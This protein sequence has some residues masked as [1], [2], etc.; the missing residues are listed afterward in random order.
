[1]SELRVI[2]ILVKVALMITNCTRQMLR[3]QWGEKEKV[4]EQN[5]GVLHTQG[6]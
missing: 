2:S 5:L 6:G 1:M 4:T 3:V